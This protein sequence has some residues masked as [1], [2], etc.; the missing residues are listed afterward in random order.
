[1]GILFFLFIALPVL[2]VI[3][4]LWCVMCYKIGSWLV[5]GLFPRQTWLDLLADVGFETWT[6]VDAY[7]RDT[8]IGR[9]PA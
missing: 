2:G 9:R 3:V 5:E 7:E 8:F 6:A 4:L 1:M